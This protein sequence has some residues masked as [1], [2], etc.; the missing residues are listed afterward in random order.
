M[1]D[2]KLPSYEGLYGRAFLPPVMIVSVGRWGSK[3]ASR[4]FHYLSGTFPAR[5]ISSCFARI[6]VVRDGIAGYEL[7]WATDVVPWPEINGPRLPLQA[8][9]D[10]QEL[11]TTPRSAFESVAGQL[12]TELARKV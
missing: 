10:T 1:P 12:Y 7:N 8:D 3:A 9:S 2:L 6:A 11:W 4:F 5:D